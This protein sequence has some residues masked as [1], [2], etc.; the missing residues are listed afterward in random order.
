MNANKNTE[1]APDRAT[2]IDRCV[3]CLG[4]GKV[5]PECAPWDKFGVGPCPVCDGNGRPNTVRLKTLCVGDLFADVNGAEF[6]VASKDK[7]GCV[8]VHQC[9]ERAN[10]KEYAPHN[11]AVRLLRRADVSISIPTQVKR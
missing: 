8:I 1:L 7:D 3:A 5:L 9:G 6:L 10:Q 11:P 4:S 2:P